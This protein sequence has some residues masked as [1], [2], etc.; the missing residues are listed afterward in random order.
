MKNAGYGFALS[1]FLLGLLPAPA[2]AG[3]P[4]WPSFRGAQ[5]AGVAEGPAPTTWNGETAANVLWQT[6]IP[7]LAHSSPV[8]W[9]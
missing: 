5:A 9:G 8:V 6:P 2:A 1:A 3:D 7:G 4:A